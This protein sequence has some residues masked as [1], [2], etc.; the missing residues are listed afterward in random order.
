MNNEGDLHGEIT[1]F[2]GMTE[3]GR[4]VELIA[5]ECYTV[6]VCDARNDAI[7]IAAGLIKTFTENIKP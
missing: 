2:A 1:A 5:A 4:R 7:S 3:E 6:Q